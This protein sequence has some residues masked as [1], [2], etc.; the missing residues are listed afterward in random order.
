MNKKS[1]IIIG[2]L[3]AIILVLVTVIVVGI[4][5]STNKAIKERKKEEIS[6]YTA[7]EVVEYLE[8]QGY[9]FKNS[10]YTYIYTTKY[11][12]VSN[13]NNSIAFQ[14]ITSNII[15]ISYSWKNGDIND[16]WPEIK[17]TYKNKTDEE[18]KQ[19]KEYEKWLEYEGLTTKQLTDALD[20]YGN[21]G[22]EYEKMD[23]LLDN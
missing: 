14:K 5:L 22:G 2:I 11:V 8:E 9:K 21:Y 6:K 12:Y 10:E 17:S 7:R 19:Y 1:K 15:G 4:V 18:E 13:E 23:L 3:I 16:A 20:Y